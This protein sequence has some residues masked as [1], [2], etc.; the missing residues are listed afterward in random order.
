MGVQEFL[1]YNGDELYIYQLVEGS[2]AHCQH[3]LAFAPINVTEIPRFL[4]Q[5]KQHGELKMSKNFRK[6]VRKQLLH[7]ATLE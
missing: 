4:Q 2:Y 6:W 5:S 3:S 7:F 1:R